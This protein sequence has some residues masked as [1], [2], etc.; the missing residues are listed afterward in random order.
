MS[1]W[2]KDQPGPP[3]PGWYEKHPTTKPPTKTAP[4]WLSF[5]CINL[6]YRDA[7][8]R[9][10]SRA[11]PLL[12]PGPHPDEARRE[13]NKI[14]PGPASTGMGR[15]GP[16]WPPVAGFDRPN[17]FQLAKLECPGTAAHTSATNHCAD[18]PGRLPNI[19]IPPRTSAAHQ[20]LRGRVLCG[21]PGSSGIA[22]NASG[23]LKAGKTLFK[24]QAE[25]RVNR[26]P[27][28]NKKAQPVRAEPFQKSY[29]AAGEARIE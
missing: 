11:R 12:R 13:T 6:K 1:G 25:T 7:F 24:R 19:V 15:T 23:P 16:G 8:S 9:T 14:Q 3:N 20:P 17:R 10:A 22:F 5:E 26:P 4:G 21:R 29:S 2:E 18:R 28:E 27:F